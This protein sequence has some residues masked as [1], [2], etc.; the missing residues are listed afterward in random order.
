[1]DIGYEK[2]GLFGFMACESGSSP[3]KRGSIDNAT[4]V[5]PR[6]RYYD[7]RIEKT[8]ESEKHETYPYRSIRPNGQ[9]PEALCRWIEWRPKRAARLSERLSRSDEFCR[10][11]ETRATGAPIVGPAR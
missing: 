11:W 10:C 8:T 2:I 9:P 3:L 6:G 1:M 5:R 4:I 7:L